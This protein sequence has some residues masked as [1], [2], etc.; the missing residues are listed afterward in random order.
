MR[1]APKEKVF[2]EWFMWLKHVCITFK[3]INKDLNI[4]ICKMQVNRHTKQKYSKAPTFFLDYLSGKLKPRT[5]HLSN[6][7]T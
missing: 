3:K 2:L 6:F 1:I 7:G 5:P 4:N